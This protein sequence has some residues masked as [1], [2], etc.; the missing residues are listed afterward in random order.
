MDQIIGLVG[1]K[2][3]GKGTFVQVLKKFMP[4]LD[5]IRFS[6]VLLAIAAELG[7]PKEKVS[8]EQ[9]QKLAPALEKIFGKGCITNGVRARIKKSRSS[10]IVLDGIRWPSDLEMLRSFPNNTLVYVT[11]D[12]QIR[13]QRTQK[14]KEKSGEDKTNLKKFLK[15]EKA[16]TEKYIP[17]IGAKA[18]YK[19]ENNG[20]LEKFRRKVE[21]FYIFKTR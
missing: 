10:T 7:I 5:H 3:G 18:D 16:E 21:V 6:D 13:L 1:E 4:G 14:R 20:P 9:L 12:P 8:R 15:E 2:G 11:A 19:L 17:E